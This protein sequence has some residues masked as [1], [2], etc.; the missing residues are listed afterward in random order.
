MRRL[1]ILATTDFHGNSE[2]FRKTATKAMQSKAD[3]IVISGDITHFGSLQNGRELLSL[4]LKLNV[5]VLFVPGNCDPPEL[6]TETFEMIESIH[7]KCL[8]I[9]N[10]SF[11]GLGGSSPC[12]FTTPYELSELE[13]RDILMRT[14]NACKVQ[15]DAILVSHSPPKDTK[16]DITFSKEH[17]GSLSVREFIEI[18]KPKL[19]LCGHIH[20]ALGLDKIN[21]TVLINPGPARHGNCAL[22]DLNG[23]IKVKF[24]RL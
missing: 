18:T 11:L 22:I 5:P 12:P 24:E 10:T 19:V 4:L 21:E 13:I 23:K 3:V 8:Q 6:A 17:V 14:Y 16:V 15:C 2:A 1:K 20:E 7:G 9:Y